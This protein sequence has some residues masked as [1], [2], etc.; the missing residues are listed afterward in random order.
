MKRFRL[1]AGPNGS[2][3]STIIKNARNSLVNGRP[4]DFGVYVNADDIAVDLAKGTFTFATYEMDKI[5]MVHLAEY[6]SISGLFR[7]G[8]NEEAL[9]EAI[10]LTGDNVEL[11]AKNLVEMVAQLLSNF[12]IDQLLQAGK[13]CT[14]ET[15]FSHFS[16]VQFMEQ[17][18]SLGYKV[19]LYFVTTSNPEINV[20][21]VKLRVASNGHNVP[22]NRIRERYIKSLDLMYAA[23]QLAYQAYFFDNSFGPDQHQLVA[24]FKV[25]DGK[26]NWDEFDPATLPGWFIEYYLNKQTH[27]GRSQTTGE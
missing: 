22:E 18:N 14:M 27:I 23:A 1:F 24:H 19:Y 21:R 25:T 12:L 6:A 9:Y 15:V 8:F 5:T 2:G 26:K 13:K 7:N 4:L 20:E 10:T 17:A 11:N 3:K 16:K